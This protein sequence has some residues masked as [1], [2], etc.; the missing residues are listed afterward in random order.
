[1]CHV[2]TIAATCRHV[3]CVAVQELG[4]LAALAIFAH[5]I[6]GLMDIINHVP[7]IVAGY[8]AGLLDIDELWHVNWSIV[9]GTRV[10][11]S[12]FSLLFDL[13]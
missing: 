5:T 12:P 3:L 4:L 13:Q 8:M 7:D 9:C 6:I 10:Y 11:K 2:Q 1:M